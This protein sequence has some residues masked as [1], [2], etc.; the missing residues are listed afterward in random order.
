MKTSDPKLLERLTAVI[1]EALRN[2]KHP[3]VLTVEE[4]PGGLTEIDGTFDLSVVAIACFAEINSV[5]RSRLDA[6][7]REEKGKAR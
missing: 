7:L 6:L 4:L 2:G 3:T 1:R 5:F